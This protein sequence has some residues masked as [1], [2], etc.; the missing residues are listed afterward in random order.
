MAPSIGASD[1][2]NRRALKRHA[3]AY[4]RSHVPRRLTALD[5]AWPTAIGRAVH[6]LL[7]WSVEGYPGVRRGV[8]E[9]LAGRATWDAFKRWRRGERTM[10][11]WFALVLAD[12]I[13][14]R[15]R[16]GLAIVTELRDYRAPIHRNRGAVAVDPAT[17]R[18]R[19]GGRIGRTGKSVSPKDEASVPIGLASCGADSPGAIQS[20]VRPRTIAD[21][22][23]RAASIDQASNV[24]PSDTP[25]DFD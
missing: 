10:P 14:A 13:E 25:S 3:I 6:W 18:D 16:A 19:R 9:L 15:C 12:M 1:P 17:G 4:A 8:G 20:S 21:P 23:S 22:R 2:A 7:P 11:V 24:Q 5:K